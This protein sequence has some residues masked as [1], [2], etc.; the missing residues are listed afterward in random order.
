MDGGSVFAL[1]KFDGQKFAVIKQANDI[2]NT[3]FIIGFGELS[4]LDGV[5]VL[6]PGANDVW[7]IG[8]VFKNDSLKSSLRHKI[9][10]KIAI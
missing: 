8:E 9:R 4:G 7:V 3:L 2:G 6:S 1:L 10:I 5:G